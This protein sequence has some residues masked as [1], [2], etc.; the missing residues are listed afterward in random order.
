M[1]N[2]PNRHTSQTPLFGLIAGGLEQSVN[3]TGQHQAFEK[4]QGK[5]SEPALK[6]GKVS[7]ASRLKFLLGQL[8]AK[9]EN[10]A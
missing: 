4:P 1:L 3:F 8:Q 9:T 7:L 10:W 5:L 6:A 2:Q